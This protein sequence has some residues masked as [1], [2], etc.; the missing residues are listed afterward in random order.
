MDPLLVAKLLL[1]PILIGAISVAAR[2]FGPRVGGALAGLPWTSSAVSIFLALEH[3]AAFAQDAAWGTESAV[4]AVVVFC[5]V[6]AL[7]ARRGWYV[8][9]PAAILAFLA[10]VFVAVRFWAPSILEGFLVSIAVLVLAIVTFPRRALAP[11]RA[12]APVWEIPLR[13]VAATLLVLALT[14]FA[15]MLG[16]DWTGALSPFPVFASVLGTF[17]HHRDG[18]DAARRFLWGVMMGL[19]SF[20]T[21]FLA[22]GTLLEQW[23]LVVT[24]LFAAG[25]ALIASLASWLTWLR[26]RSKQ[27]THVSLPTLP[28]GK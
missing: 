24:Y 20:A 15:K 17:I 22:V 1:T 23:G 7:L 12:P 26:L 8:S 13:M 28:T 27:G 2:H 11:Q 18:P 6:Y 10:A 4:P 3:G 14:G 19:I 9:L 25:V 16:P 5:S 21:F